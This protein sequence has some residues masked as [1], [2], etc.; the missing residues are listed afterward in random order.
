MTSPQRVHW[1]SRRQK[2]GMRARFLSIAL[3]LGAR[4]L[5]AGEAPAI[6][7]VTV[8]KAFFNPTLRQTVD[9]SLTVD[10]EGLLSVSILDRDGFLVRT[11][12]PGRP[13]T[14]GSHVFG[15]DGKDDRGDVVPDEA[16]SLKIDLVSEGARVASYFPANQPPEDLKAEPSYYD[17]G[18]AVFAYKLPKAARV[19]MQA[20]IKH[21]DPATKKKDG[22][23]LKT[24]VNREPRPGGPVIEN[25]NG[26]DETGSYYLPD[27][28]DFV[29]AMAATSLPENTVITN[30]NHS[31]TFLE[32]A[33][34]RHGSSL[35][36]HTVSD[37]HHHRGLTSLED[38]SPALRVIPSNATWSATNRLWWATSGSLKGSLSLEG[39]SAREFQTQPGSLEI[40][41]D[42]KVVRKEKTPTQGMSFEVQLAG[43]SKG[44]HIVAFNWASEYGP[45][46]ISSIRVSAGG[47]LAA[48]PG[49]EAGK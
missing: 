16:Y 34:Q 44:P 46:A 13:T 2:D 5:L 43:L 26:M 11:L 29:M 6:H 18:S 22:P 23:V 4:G 49:K 32:Q 8:S 10:V 7:S 37:H 14:T 20:G 48:S 3:V 9:F 39:P 41:I 40:F 24:I 12:V 38:A 47:D 45:A 17:R 30:G 33:L 21:L 28:P 27:L 19:H 25:W 36:T 42:H 35:L 1:P 15:W 31:R